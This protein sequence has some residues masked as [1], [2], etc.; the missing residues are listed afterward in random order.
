MPE[1]APYV[2]DSETW[3]ERRTLYESLL[4][5]PDSVLLLALESEAVVGYA[6]AHVLP[7]RE[8][9][10]ADTWMTGA[11]VAEIES[12]SVLPECRGLG[13]GSALLDVLER[14]LIREGVDDVIVGALAG[15]ESALRLYRRRGFGRRGSISLV[16]P[17]GHASPAADELPCTTTPVAAPERGP[18]QA[19][20]R[21][22]LKISVAPPQAGTSTPSNRQAPADGVLAARVRDDWTG[23][24]AGEPI[25]IPSLVLAYNIGYLANALPTPGGI[26][27]LD[28]GLA[29]SLI[30][31]GAAPAHVTAAVLVYHAIA[32]WIPG[33][34][35]TLAY[36]RVRPHLTPSLRRGLGPSP[37]RTRRH[38]LSKNARRGA[39]RDGY[40]ATGTPPNG[41]ERPRRWLGPSIT[42]PASN[43]KSARARAHRTPPS[44]RGC[45]TNQTRCMNRTMTVWPI[46]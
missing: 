2:S 12:L 28:A 40:S 32:L 39:D 36:L 31:Y 9:W 17:G 38:K 4:T 7:V 15:H 37:E 6:L 25:S 42:V 34:G 16:S 13:L 46:S 19:D 5:R 21:L 33:L 8:T 29:G 14:E 24:A 26:G 10:I 1:L 30:L 27:A 35:G 43:R 11:R 45:R 44:R 18:L 20:T 41:L 23:T 3:T 22:D